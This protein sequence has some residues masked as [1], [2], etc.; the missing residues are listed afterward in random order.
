MSNQKSTKIYGY[1]D[2]VLL[3]KGN[4]SVWV[5]VDE[6]VLGEYGF[7]KSLRKYF[8]EHSVQKCIGIVENISFLP[9]DL[10]KTV[11]VIAGLPHNHLPRDIGEI[12][13]SRF[14]LILISPQY[15]PEDTCIDFKA[16]NSVEVF[17]GEFSQSPY[18]SAWKGTDKVHLISG[19]GDFFPNWPSIIFEKE[20]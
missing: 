5:V 19:V 8:T 3:G 20:L 18:L 1:R 4:P 10:S 6:R 12:A 16:T 7:A 15:Y 13:T 11:V 14:R 2:F 9:P 17:Y